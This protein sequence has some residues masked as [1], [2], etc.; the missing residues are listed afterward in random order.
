MV[1]DGENRRGGGTFAKD[2]DFTRKSA[3]WWHVTDEGIGLI[4]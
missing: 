4:E 1:D 3:R 2:V